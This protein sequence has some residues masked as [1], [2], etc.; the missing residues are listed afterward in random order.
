MESLSDLEKLKISRC[1][2]PPEFGEIARTEHHHFCDGSLSGYGACSYVRF[3]NKQQQV[4]VAL[5]IAK[6]RVVPL[7]ST[8][9]VP[10]LELQAAVEAAHLSNV[11]RSELQMD[12]DAEFFWSDS[13]ITL[14]RI[15]NSNA[16]YHMFVANRVK[17]IRSLSH[18]DQWFFIAGSM[19][20]ADIVS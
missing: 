13:Q 8:M 20:P 4:H 10:R 7:K 15:K 5:L 14:G 17:E 18:P 11:L 3:T 6:S 12:F 1:I 2:K 16:R 9:T 19:N